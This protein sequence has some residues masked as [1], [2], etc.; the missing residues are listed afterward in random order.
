MAP[1]PLNMALIPLPVDELERLLVTGVPTS[2]Q[3]STYWGRNSREKYAAMLESAIFTFLGV[4][5]SYF[6]SFV[7]GGFVATV[8]G[9][10][11]AMWTLLS[12]EL[13][14]YTRNWEFRGGRQ[15]VDPWV[16]KEF[17]GPENEQGLYG[18]LF[19]GR[20][21]D[22]CVVEEASDVEEYDLSEF[23]DYTM[24]TDELEQLF[25]NP[26]SLRVRMKDNE[27]RKIQVHARMSEEY[28]DLEPG[29]AV[30]GVLLSTSQKF[31]RL[32]ALTDFFVPEE[33][34]WIGDYPYLDRSELERLLAED[35]ELWDILESQT[36]SGR[37]AGEST[38][39]NAYDDNRDP[40]NEEGDMDVDIYY[41]G[42][43][44]DKNALVP[45]RRRKK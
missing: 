24:E 9:S 25:G 34:C 31:S 13:K 20:V 30:A 35:D 37:P 41:D 43:G 38:S 18:G 14:A 3:Y 22:V 40:Y 33:E 26:Y 4:F 39:G 27:G 6:L 8:L 1:L 2:A 12:P 21:S 28:L 11:C 32:N 29:Q 10:L 45:V 42:E 5:M 19:L 23:Q 7:L 15:L 44:T 17:E 16:V 36:Q